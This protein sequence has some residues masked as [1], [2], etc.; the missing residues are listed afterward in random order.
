[1]ADQ[2]MTKRAALETQ[3]GRILNFF[4]SERTRKKWSKHLKEKSRSRMLRRAFK[5]STSDLRELYRICSEHISPV[6]CPLALISQVQRSGG[7]LLSQLFDGH[8]EI[9]AHPHEL[10]IGQRKKYIWPDI[11]LNDSPERWFEILF[12][13]VNLR[14]FKEGYR[15]MPKHGKHNESFLFVFL[16]GLQKKIFS[17]YI[18]SMSPMTRRGVFDAYMTSYFGA[19][20]N[21]QNRI[22]EKKFVTAFTPRLAMS[23]DNVASFF[24]IYPDGRLISLIRNPKNWYPSAYRHNRAIKKKKYRDIREAIHQWMESAESMLWNKQA[25]RDRVCIIS[26]EDMVGKTEAVMGHLAAFLGIAFSDILLTP[27]FNRYPIKAN[28]SFNTEKHGI[29]SSTLS[30]YKTLTEEESEVIETMAEATYLQVLDEAVL[31]S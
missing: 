9:H 1:M 20:L 21:N 7:S 27:T 30:R 29:V 16:P 4:L 24:E 23:K 5:E 28:T 22:G 10:K 3:G 2:E 14:L 25:Y 26:F 8:P 19:W 15:K 12:E 6:T 31:F 17:T 18:R 11:D 13:D